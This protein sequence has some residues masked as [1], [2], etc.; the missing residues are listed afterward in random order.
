MWSERRREKGYYGGTIART[1]RWAQTAG[2]AKYHAL[3]GVRVRVEYRAGDV[4]L[5]AVGTLVADSGKSIFLEER[6][7]KSE[8]V[9]CFRWELPYHCIMKIVKMNAEPLAPKDKHNV[10]AGAA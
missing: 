9:K 5:P 4:Y 7:E 10:D 2:M 8:S 6:F 3:L 1:N